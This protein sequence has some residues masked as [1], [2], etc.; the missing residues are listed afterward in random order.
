MVPFV[1]T[2]TL[3]SK[4]MRYALPLAS[5]LEIT[6]LPSASVVGVTVTSFS[7][8]GMIFPSIFVFTCTTLIELLSTVPT[9]N[10]SVKFTVPILSLPK[11]YFTVQLT[12]SALSLDTA[13]SFW[14]VGMSLENSTSTLAE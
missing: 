14:M 13:P 4:V 12:I 6:T 9:S 1:P 7:V 5:K 2:G 11:L 8:P 3:E 10:L